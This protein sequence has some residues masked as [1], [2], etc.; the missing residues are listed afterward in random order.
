LLSPNDVIGT[1]TPEQLL[2]AFANFLG[3][4]CPVNSRLQGLFIAHCAQSRRVDMYG[5]EVAAM[6][7][8]PGDHR[9]QFHNEIV[10]VVG[11]FA[12]AASI[13]SAREPQNM[14]GSGIPAE[15][16]ALWQA[17]GGLQNI[18]PDLQLSGV[19]PLQSTI[20]ATPSSTSRLSPTAKPATVNGGKV[21]CGST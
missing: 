3:E 5:D 16:Y 10:R 17:S 9:R 8:L 15:N 6:P 21:P 2:V 14:F 19:P 11:N 20:S 1:F 7:T 18:V 4:P 12:R 13:T